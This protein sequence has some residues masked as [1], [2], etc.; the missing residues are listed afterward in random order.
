MPAGV[1]VTVTG[2]DGSIFRIEKT[3]TTSK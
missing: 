3:D 2:I 1:H